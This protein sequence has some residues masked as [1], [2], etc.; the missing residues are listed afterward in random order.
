MTDNPGARYPEGLVNKVMKR[1]VGPA[2]VDA[3]PPEPKKEEQQPKKAEAPKKKTV[4]VFIP[5][6]LGEGDYHCVMG[7]T[8]RVRIE[9]IK[10]RV[11]AGA[12]VKQIIGFT[13]SATLRP[14]DLAHGLTHAQDYAR[15][16][17]VAPNIVVRGATSEDLVGIHAPGSPLRGKSG[18][19]IEIVSEE[20]RV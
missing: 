2:I 20:P 15:V 19:I 14:N 9:D 12:E 4:S 17:S 13:S 16:L 3:K 18:V 10:R 1:H 6:G 8:A 7:E 5:C 11:Q